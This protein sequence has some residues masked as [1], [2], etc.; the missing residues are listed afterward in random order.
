MAPSQVFAI[1]RS[2]D[3]A[4]TL[5]E[6]LALAPKQVLAAAPISSQALAVAPCPLSL[7]FQTHG[8]MTG[9][10]SMFT[11]AEACRVAHEAL[12]EQ[13]RAEKKVPQLGV[14]RHDEGLNKGQEEEEE[15]E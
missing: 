14:S 4:E 7:S 11:S 10:E 9:A 5:S 12:R 8:E 1:A 6:V 13:K 15:E 3:F 2:E